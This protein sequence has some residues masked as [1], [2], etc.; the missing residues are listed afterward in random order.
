MTAVAYLLIPVL[1]FGGLFATCFFREPRRLLNGLLFN[2]FAITVLTAAAGLI[3][4]SNNRLLIA[5]SATLFIILLLV[6]GVLFALHLVWLLWN[7]RVV[8]RREGHSLGNALTLLLAL[9]LLLLEIAASVGRGFLPDPVYNGLAV[10]FSL[11]IAYE[12]VALYNFLTAL[13]LYNLYRPR[14]DKDFLIVLGAGLLGGDK[15]SPL[16]AARINAGIKFYDKQ[17]AKTGKRATLV[18]SGGQGADEKLPEGLAMQR[19][20]VA[21]GVPEA[22]TLVEDASKTTYQNMLFSKRLIERQV[23]GAPYKAAFFTNNYHLL[24]AGIFAR[25]AGLAANGVGAATSF[26]FLPNAVIREYLAFVVIHK[27]RHIVIIGLI[28]ALGLAIALQQALM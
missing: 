15:V 1:L 22:D 16:L 10:F 17:L 13:V 18:F 26:Y 25:A 14:R 11:S 2:L 19:F 24:R 8:W 6:I 23:K 4:G 20:A 27:R 5:V 28:A 12:L 9:A 3:L 21:Q 7:A